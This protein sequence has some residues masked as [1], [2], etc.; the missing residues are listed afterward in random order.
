[1]T[2]LAMYGSCAT[3]GMANT[4]P[5]LKKI[6]KVQHLVLNEQEEVVAGEV[7][8]D[9]PVFLTDLVLRQRREKITWVF[10]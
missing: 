10:D 9:L 6:L 1:M 3:T 8:R 7:W 2:C 4:I 5:H